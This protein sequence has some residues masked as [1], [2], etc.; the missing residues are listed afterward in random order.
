M[1]DGFDHLL[2]AYEKGKLTRRQLLAA[3][4][5]TSTAVSAQQSSSPLSGRAR[6]INHINV[7]VSNLPRSAA[8]YAKLGL[9]TTLR[10]IIPPIGQAAYALDFQ[11]GSLLSL[12][13]TP[14][15]ER[16]GTID[17]FCIGLDDFDRQRDAEAIRAS[18]I[19][20]PDS[21]LDAPESEW[22]FVRD[23]DGTSVQI[24][25]AKQIYA[26]PSGIGNPP[27]APV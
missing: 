9:P 22:F 19:D 14:E 27:C 15:T 23:P 12:I 21:P 7:R 13:Q 18:G 17:H 11:D 26:C 5:M 10:P 16:V 24:S 8:F 4:V 20:V 25:D 2:T 1:E 6:N 3:L